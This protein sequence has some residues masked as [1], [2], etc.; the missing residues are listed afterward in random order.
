MITSVVAQ[1]VPLV[2]GIS[3]NLK[4]IIFAAGWLG[5]LVGGGYVSGWAFSGSVG[6]VVD[7]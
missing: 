4:W 2:S 7:V 1:L 6:V 3:Y 5:G